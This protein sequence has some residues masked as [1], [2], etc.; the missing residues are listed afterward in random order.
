MGRLPI[1]RLPLVRRAVDDPTIESAFFASERR[2]PHPKDAPV[3]IVSWNI[4]LGRALDRVHASLRGS[5]N[6]SAAAVIALQEVS[7][8]RRTSQARTLAARLKMNYVYAG[9]H[10][11]RLARERGQAILTPYPI[12]RSWR[13]ALPQVRHPRI[14]LAADLAVGDEVLRVVNVHLENRTRVNPFIVRRRAAQ[15]T[16]LLEWLESAG[17]ARTVLV[18]DLNTLGFIV[19]RGRSE[20][21]LTAL[22]EAAGFRDAHHGRESVTF[23]LLGSRLDWIFAR[24][25]VTLRAAVEDTGRIS[26]HLAVWADVELR[27]LPAAS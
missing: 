27:P 26:D 23:R 22:L 3:R 10:R 2:N 12:L 18:G 15:L 20:V 16:H 7:R 9:A 19:D 1:Q 21:L 5:R 24:H 11:C 4:A 8:T 17:H 6:L 25:A 14:A 13:I